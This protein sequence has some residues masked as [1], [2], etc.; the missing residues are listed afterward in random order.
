MLP[1]VERAE[2]IQTVADLRIIGFEPRLADRQGA[3]QKRFGL[4]EAALQAVVGAEV[5]KQRIEGEYVV[6]GDLFPKSDRLLVRA[7]GFGVSSG[8]LEHETQHG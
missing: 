8:G 6:R 5:H 4:G 1:A 2:V 3:A 7:F